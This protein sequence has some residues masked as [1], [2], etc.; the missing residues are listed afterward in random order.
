MGPCRVLNAAQRASAAL[1][2]CAAAAREDTNAPG[3]AVGRGARRPAGQCCRSPPP[4][5]PH[6][7]LARQV[8]CSRSGPPPAAAVSR[9]CAAL[10]PPPPRQP[11]GR[12]AR[13]SREMQVYLSL[14][15]SVAVLTLLEPSLTNTNVVLL[16]HDLGVCTVMMHTYKCGLD[17]TQEQS[18]LPFLFKSSQGF[19][20][21]I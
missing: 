17:R 7:P 5:Q 4:P 13:R 12:A 2:A 11:F 1:G 16:S 10:V 14:L 3:P 19:K 15:L 21:H 9:F 8:F 20:R 6:F 18:S